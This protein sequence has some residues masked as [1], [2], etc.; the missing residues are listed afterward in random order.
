MAFYDLTMRCLARE[1]PKDMAFLSLGREVDHID[2]LS[3]DLPASERRADWLAQVQVDE[4]QLLVQTEFQTEYDAQKMWSML[5]YRLRAR[6][7]HG[8]PVFSTIVYLTEEGYPGPG[9]H[10]LEDVVLDQLQCVFECHEVRLWELN[11]EG[12]LKGG[13]AGLIG[14]VPLMKGHGEGPLERALE[15]ASSVPDNSRKADLMT[16]IAVLGSLRYPADFLRTL[17]RREA[18]K[19]SAIYQEI[20]DEGLNEGR[21]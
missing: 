1:F 21:A 10:R 20:F 9:R 6:H 7:T 8:L 15:A 13:H 18:M 11:P 4:E 17:I 3:P 14:L 12:I 2:T 16:A 19:D 5:D